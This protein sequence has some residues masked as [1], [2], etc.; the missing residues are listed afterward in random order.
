MEGAM[1]V[2]KRSIQRTE[3]LSEG[4]VDNE[5][6]YKAEQLYAPGYCCATLYL[7]R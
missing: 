4:G 7:A 1:E 5:V 2:I 6:R 3:K